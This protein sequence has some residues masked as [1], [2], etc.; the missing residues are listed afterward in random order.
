MSL[1]ELVLALSFALALP[2]P[3][4]A[5][6]DDEALTEAALSL[7][8]A[9]RFDGAAV[10]DALRAAGSDLPSARAR[11]F[12]NET[13]ANAWLAE[14][15]SEGDAPLSCGRVSGPD[16]VLAIASHRG[17]RLQVR[18]ATIDGWVHPSFREAHWVVVAGDDDPRWEPF[19]RR[20]PQL[21][22]EPGT[23]EVQLLATGPR[24]PRPVASV[25]LR[26][27]IAEA[28][29]PTIRGGDAAARLRAVREHYGQR[30]LRPNRI[31]ARA[32]QE[33][34]RRVCREGRVGHLAGD[35][36]PEAR[37]RAGGIR[38]RHVGEVV[39]RAADLD[40]LFDALLRSTSHRLTMIDRRFTDVGVGV[41]DTGGAAC[42]VIDLAAWPRY[43]GTR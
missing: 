7:Y 9:P 38:A 31:L 28:A 1:R 25:R 37:L 29:L 6:E 20:N 16:G 42:V 23:R 35:D 34:A 2:A 36:D 41:V 13:S 43:A 21:Q 27:E 30:A 3:T 8:L 40:E 17:G 33:H 5:C 11:R 12:A 24:G 39:G 10:G 19:D 18:G 32:A 15:E 26:R 14:L 22:L 4:W